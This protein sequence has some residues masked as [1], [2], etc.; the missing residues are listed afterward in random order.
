MTNYGYT[1][2]ENYLITISWNINSFYF[3]SHDYS[4]NINHKYAK[5]CTK[6]YEIIEIEDIKNDDIINDD[7]ILN[8]LSDIRIYLDK[9]IFFL[10][11]KRNTI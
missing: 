1:I 2:Y 6:K 8:K 11:N 10:D 4:M 5:Y 7:K 9:W 3:C